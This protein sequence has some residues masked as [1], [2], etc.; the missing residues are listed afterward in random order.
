MPP[1]SDAADRPQDGLTGGAD[2]AT[3]DLVATLRP[4]QEKLATLTK[5]LQQM[6]SG[7]GLMDKLKAMRHGGMEN[8]M[9]SMRDQIAEV[10]KSMADKI[11]PPG[12]PQGNGAADP[13]KQ[14][15]DQTEKL[16][17]QMAIDKELK[18]NGLPGLLTDSQRDD[19]QKQIE[20]N[21]KAIDS[22]SEDKAEKQ[23]TEHK[24]SV[25]ESLGK[26]LGNQQHGQAIGGPK[27][28]GPSH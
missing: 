20:K 27:Q 4:D 15:Q 2:Q 17:R 8:A 28:H 5:Q 1:P 14:M 16:Q 6:E 13:V 7:P 26:G 24:A 25:R 11:S 22:L 10:Q 3:R 18:A 21:K 19:T 9:E 23:G 12:N